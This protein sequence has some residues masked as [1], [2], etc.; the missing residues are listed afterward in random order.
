MA[1]RV[2]AEHRARLEQEALMRAEEARLRA[3][4]AAR[5]EQAARLEAIR[6]AEAEREQLE[7]EQRARIALLEQQQVHERRLAALEHDAH[8]RR[9]TGALYMGAAFAALL[10]GGTAGVYFGYVRPQVERAHQREL[11]AIAEREAQ[12]EQLKRELARATQR[13]EDAKRAVQQRS[14]EVDQGEGEAAR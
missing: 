8:K 2:Q 14:G 9:I 4:A 11:S 3:E 12:V 6:L 5:R 13:A 10:F 7:T 1:A